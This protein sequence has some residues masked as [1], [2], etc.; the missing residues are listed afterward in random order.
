MGIN[1]DIFEISNINEN[2]NEIEEEEEEEKEIKINKKILN[3]NGDNNNN[4]N[5]SNNSTISLI[6]SIKRIEPICKQYKYFKNYIEKNNKYEKGKIQQS[7]CESLQEFLKV[8]L[9]KLIKINK[10]K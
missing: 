3:I 2:E 9:K 6:E 1:N 8:K 4:N 10:K 7:F 5:S